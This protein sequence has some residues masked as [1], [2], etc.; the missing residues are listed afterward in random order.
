M[1]EALPG[2]FADV[3]NRKRASEVA[4]ERPPAALPCHT[5]EQ[6]NPS[7]LSRGGKTQRDARLRVEIEIQAMI[8]R[9]GVDRVG[10]LTFTFADDVQ[11]IKEASRRFNS[12]FS[13][14]LSGRYPEWLAVVQRHKD[15]R[16]H[17]HLVV[18][19]TGD[20]RTGF[21]FAAVARRDY[22]SA[23]PYLRAEWKF[24]RESMPEYQFGRHELLPIKNTDGFGVYV[25]RYVGRTF[26][27]RKEE[28]GARLVRFS[29][30]FQRAVLGPFSKLDIIGKRARNRLPEVVKEF[31][32]K[33]QS[34]LENELG[35]AWRFHLSRLLYCRD[36]VFRCILYAVGHDLEYF[37]GVRTALDERFSE[38]DRHGRLYMALNS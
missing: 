26:H 36:E 30:S 20:I 14:R 31:G 24:L 22:S 38:W 29:K 13:N 37:N 1:N 28:K 17:F 25:A 32:F 16:I 34:A 27:T 15:D 35:P 21:D 4:A 12:M 10:F 19:L 3:N 6:L 11:T 33:S 5:S 7:N 18:A 9:H 23:S 2:S 8:M